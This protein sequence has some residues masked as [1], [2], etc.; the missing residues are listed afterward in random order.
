MGYIKNA[1]CKTSEIRNPKSE[2]K[3]PFYFN[4]KKKKERSMK[5]LIGKI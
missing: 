3:I 2:I 5:A 1:Q 4:F